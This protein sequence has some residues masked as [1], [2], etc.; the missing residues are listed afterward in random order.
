MNII[1]FYLLC[2]I[3]FSRLLFQ[4]DIEEDSIKVRNFILK[5]IFELLA[6]MLIIGEN[7]ALLFSAII[8]LNMI[9]FSLENRKSNHKRF[10]SFCLY[11]LTFSFLVQTDFQFNQNALFLKTFLVE[12]NILAQYL[13]KYNWNNILILL[14]GALFVINEANNPIKY[15]LVNL[16]VLPQDDSKKIDPNE[17]NRGKI[18]GLIE[19]LLI[20]T[21]VISN[22]MSG[23]AFIIAAKALARFDDLKER[24]FAEYFLIGTLLSVS[25]AFYTGIIIKAIIST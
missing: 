4:T 20:Y 18:I 25:L 17:L 21:L 23:I 2:L 12:H 3:L 22:N 1:F 13:N 5:T 7:L 16:N 19:R 14:T 6:I 9:S 24:D 15:I 11:V 8:L 10:L